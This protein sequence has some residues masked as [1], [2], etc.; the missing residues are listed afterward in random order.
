MLSGRVAECDIGE[1]EDA[2]RLQE[3]FGCKGPGF[4]ALKEQ[5]LRVQYRG[6]NN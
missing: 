1:L 4:R 5:G 2:P 6:L 3:G